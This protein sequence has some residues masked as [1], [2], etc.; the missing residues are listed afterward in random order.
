MYATHAPMTEEAIQVPVG[1]AFLEGTFRGP[2]GATA[3]VLF[4]HGSG[5]SRQ[6]PR[7]RLVA[8]VLERAGLATVLLRPA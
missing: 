3:V 5:S 8:G 1:R 4:A 2:E 6:S 7:N